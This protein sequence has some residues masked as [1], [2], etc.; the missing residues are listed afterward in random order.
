MGKDTGTHRLPTSSSQ[1]PGRLPLPGPGLAPGHSA[2][3]APRKPPTPLSSVG[4]L[5][6]RPTRSRGEG[7]TPA[8]TA[9]QHLGGDAHGEDGG[10]LGSG[11]P[12]PLL[13][14]RLDSAGS[15]PRRSPRT[16]LPSRLSRSLLLPEQSSADQAF[17]SSSSLS[18]FP[19]GWKAQL[20]VWQCWFLPGPFPLA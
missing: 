13:A 6:S 16:P 2:L 17:N 1:D 19:G 14:S 9:R 11:C 3:R 5:S 20:K 15:R 18:H 7:A 12:G 4:T 10:G 8:G